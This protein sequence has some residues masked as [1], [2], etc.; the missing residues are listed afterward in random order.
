MNDNT[1]DKKSFL[2]QLTQTIKSK[3]KIIIIFLTLCFVTFLIFQIY[4]VY[5]SNK[6]KNNSI[7]FFNNQNLEN[8]NYS[9]EA[10]VKLSKENGFY[11]VLSKLE[12]INKNTED[13]NYQEVNN[14]YNELLIDKKLNNTYRSAIAAKA[15]LEFI[16]INFLDLPKDY[17]Q[18]IETFISSIDDELINYQ[19]VKL[20]LKY[21]VTI[22][23]IQKNNLIYTNNNDAINL[24]NEIIS[25]N[26]SS[27]I[28]ERV[29]K[30]HEFLTYK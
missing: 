26:A 4:S 27:S 14:L 25:S 29:N 1:I 2:N 10:I 5:S 21:L 20:E 11:G 19:G 7:I 24:F 13:K 18:I 8:Q 16:N 3:I 6:I 30:I 22:L 12:L 28:K 23:K 17:L 9:R 15:S